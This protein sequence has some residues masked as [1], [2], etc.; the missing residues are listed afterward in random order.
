MPH[1]P[2]GDRGGQF[3]RNQRSA[4]EGKANCNPP[5][6]SISICNAKRGFI[7]LK[8]LI[9][10]AVGLQIRP[11]CNLKKDDVA[12]NLFDLYG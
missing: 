12:L 7:G 8:I 6:L 9:P 5:E 10:N 11:Y 1:T 2:I 3:G 4:A